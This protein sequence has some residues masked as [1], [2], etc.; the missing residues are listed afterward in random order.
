[1]NSNFSYSPCF[2]SRV[3]RICWVWINLNNPGCVGHTQRREKCFERNETFYQKRSR[4]NIFNAHTK[5]SQGWKKSD[6]GV[7]YF[8]EKYRGK[9]GG[10]E[11]HLEITASFC[12]QP[13]IFSFQTRAAGK[14]QDDLNRKVNNWNQKTYFAIKAN[15]HEVSTSKKPGTGAFKS[16]KSHKTNHPT[17]CKLGQI[18]YFQFR[19]EWGDKWN[20]WKLK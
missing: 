5:W 11:G 9:D 20:L 3:A 1:M 15:F 8:W 7:K 18:H 6:E 2:S 14:G 4:K 12:T 19:R 10:K 16:G 17:K 13:T